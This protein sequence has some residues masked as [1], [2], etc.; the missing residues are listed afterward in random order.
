MRTALAKK[1]SFFLL[2][3]ASVLVACAP[4]ISIHDPQSYQA[5]I[6]LKVDFQFLVES[7]ESQY[8]DKLDEVTSFR[9]K[10]AKSIEYEKGRYKNELT[11]KQYEILRDG[12]V[13][14]FFDLWKS[15]GT[16]SEYF[17]SQNVEQ[18]NQIFDE[19]IKLE[20]IKRT[21]GIKLNTTDLLEDQTDTKE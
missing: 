9:K 21:E 7:S 6:D 20:K 17:R 19:I 10:L 12:T 8:E 5:A 4:L 14:G 3:A 1:S 13:N 2:L 11:V 15:Q 16:T 18:S